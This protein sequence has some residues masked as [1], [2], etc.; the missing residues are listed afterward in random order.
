MSEI[1]KP[2]YL[3]KVKLLSRE[4]TERLLSRMGGKLPRRLQKDKLSKEEALAIQM[5]LEDEQ[6]QHW[7]KMIR[8]LREKEA[9]KKKAK[10]EKK[11][12]GE[13]KPKA[14]KKAKD[15]TRAGA[16][17]KSKAAPGA[18]APAKPGAAK[19]AVMPVKAVVTIKAV[20]K[21]KAGTKARTPSGRG[22]VAAKA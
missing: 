19:P 9:E 15:G 11:T 4:E 8:S 7:R 2:E 22:K 12:K 20:T 5:E 13:T 1:C 6:L 3:A 14:E 18:K 16:G 17:K 10:A 21:P